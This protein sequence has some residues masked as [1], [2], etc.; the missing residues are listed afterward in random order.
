[1]WAESKEHFRHF[2][3]TQMGDPESDRA[4]WRDRSAIEFADQVTAKLLILHGTND[5]RCP[6]SQSRLFVERLRS[7]GRREGEDF[8]YV[9][10]DDEGHG[11][12]DI[13]AKIRRFSLVL[14]WLSETLAA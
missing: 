7:L 2:L 8:R 13:A 4:L 6:V 14:D 3:R 11:S 10:W 9:E 12:V 5:P 1:M